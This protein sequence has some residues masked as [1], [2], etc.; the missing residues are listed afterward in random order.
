MRVSDRIIPAALA[1]TLGGAVPAAAQPAGQPPVAGRTFAD[2]ADLVDAAPFVVVAQ[3][4][5]MARVKDERA[6]GLAPGAGRFYIEAETR[7]VLTGS[8][9]LG[10]SLRYLVDLPLD[11]RGKAPKLK[12]SDVIL[13]A[14]TVAGRPGELQLVKPDA[15]I[16]W[17]AAAETRV[18]TMLTELVA[19]DA[20]P[21]VTGVREVMY[22]PG[23]LSDEGETQI[24]LTTEDRSA[25]SITVRHKPG[26][27]PVWGVS[28]SELVADV[29][30]P[31][32][33]GTIAWYRLA[34]GLPDRLPPQS[35][36][37]GSASAR[38]RAQ[39]DYGFVIAQLGPCGR[40]PG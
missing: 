32:R 23:T 15:Q 3:V 35:N 26:E 14:R 21:R 1:L 13:F 10:E 39:E 27:P 40:T 12:K 6:P 17:T 29:G 28:F 2:M 33:P 30:N 19:A 37:S 22:V 34:C 24:F 20:P 5:K 18:R 16:V 9:P 31:P 11:S 36:L 25:A 38:A 7:R 4:R 8:A